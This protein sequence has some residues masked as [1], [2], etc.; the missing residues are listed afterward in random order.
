MPI[1]KAMPT[2]ILAQFEEEDLKQTMTITKKEGID[3]KYLSIRDKS[4]PIFK[5]DINKYEAGITLT[6]TNTLKYEQKKPK[7]HELN[8]Y[9]H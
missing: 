1:S 8:P 4:E 7:K 2:K 9:E 5:R 6:Q 3:K